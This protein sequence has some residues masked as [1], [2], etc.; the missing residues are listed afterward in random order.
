M[1]QRKSI[2][3]SVVIPTYNSARTLKHCLASVA[4]NV[5]S[6]SYEIIV[7]DAGSQ[8]ATIEIAKLYADKVI[9]G[10]PHRINRNIGVN[11]SFGKIICFTDSDCKVPENWIDSLCDG[12]LKLSKKDRSL[13]G[14]G[15]GN[16]L[17]VE[18]PTPMEQAVIKSMTSP[19]VSFKA[20]NVALYNKEFEVDHNPPMNS[21]YFKWAIEDVNGFQE[22]YGYGGEDLELDAKLTSKRFKL[23]YLPYITVVHMHRAGFNKFVS[24]MF[25]LGMGRI[26]VGSKYR[27]YLQFHHYGPVFLCLMSFTPFIVIPLIMA[28][29]NSCYITLKNKSISLLVPVILLTMAFYI[30]YGLGEISVIIKL[31]KNRI[32]KTIGSLRYKSYQEKNELNI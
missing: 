12:L 5:T 24:Q 13:V 17:S 9:H 29:I 1:T 2:E 11:N 27:D 31:W 10:I 6:Y 15:G 22:E 18:N 30:A 16:I 8:D 32:I 14:V 26:K 4:A 23:Y 21:A 25:K 7:V 19:L 3:V 20:R 28:L